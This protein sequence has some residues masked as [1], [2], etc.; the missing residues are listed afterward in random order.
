[1]DEYGSEI[2]GEVKK[3]DKFPYLTKYDSGSGRGKAYVIG[4]FHHTIASVIL[5]NQVNGL[6]AEKLKDFNKSINHFGFA[7]VYLRFKQCAS[8]CVATNGFVP[9]GS[10]LMVY[11]RFSIMATFCYPLIPN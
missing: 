8:A 9:P 10:R 2:S 4:N 1:M 5:K 6:L 3:I 7:R 11:S